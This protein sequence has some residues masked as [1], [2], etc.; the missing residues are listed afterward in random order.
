VPPR[1]DLTGDRHGTGITGTSLVPTALSP[2]RATLTRMP[3]NAAQ[4]RALVTACEQFR[5][6]EAPDG[7][8]NSLAL[9]VI[10]SIQSTGVKY[11]SVE[12]VVARY[13]AYRRD[14]RGDPNTD[15][16]PELLA[17][18]TATGGTD[19]W[20]S[21]IG[22]GHRTSTHAGAP[23]KAA[24]IRDVAEVLTAEGITTAAAL[25]DAAG[26]E[27]RFT[28]LR[29]AWCGVVGQRSGITWRYAGMLAGVP[30]VKPDRMICRFVADSLD[31]RRT[32]VGTEFAYGIVT[33]A[34]G[35]LNMTATALDHAIWRFQR[36]LK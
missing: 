15:G 19:G 14:R 5:G 20:A 36:G 9:C 25:R 2:T 3:H 30:G 6:S 18:F 7:Y 22:N 24:A 32:S 12:M 34:A 31:L 29:K 1:N 26:D 33:A 8:P 35:E 23:L 28:A 17:T 21:Q 10:D 11:P 4:L 16:I 27:V 13:R